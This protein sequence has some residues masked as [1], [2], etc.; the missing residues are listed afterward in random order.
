V[1][2][3]VTG[4]KPPTPRQDPEGDVTGFAIDKVYCSTPQQCV[5]TI[6]APGNL[7][8]EATLTEQQ[9]KVKMGEI[10]ARSRRAAED[11]LAEAYWKTGKFMSFDDARSQ[12]RR[13]L[14]SAEGFMDD[15]GYTERDRIYGYTGL[16]V[17]LVSGDIT[18][19]EWKAALE[20]MCSLRANAAQ[21]RIGT[22]DKAGVNY[23]VGSMPV[24]VRLAGWD[25]PSVT[26]MPGAKITKTV[27][28]GFLNWLY[29]NYDFDKHRPNPFGRAGQLSRGTRDTV[30]EGLEQ[31]FFNVSRAF[32]NWRLEN[33]KPEYE[34]NSGLSSSAG[35]EGGVIIGGKLGVT[36]PSKSGSAD[37]PNQFSL[38][39]FN[40][41]RAGF[42]TGLYGG[43]GVTTYY[44]NFDPSIGNRG[45]AFTVGFNLGDIGPIKLSLAIPSI[46]FTFTTRGELALEVSYGPGFGASVFTYVKPG[47]KCK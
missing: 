32:S 9:V 20:Q 5:D 36:G 22:C 37:D 42:V 31:A 2:N 33:C 25:V 12:A 21:G 4:V 46:A 43:G 47:V 34:F 44:A 18:L 19:D 10:E 45:T 41:P 39:R 27:G 11:Q 30:V 3:P 35:L 15:A 28:Q 7:D 23:K 24:G 26:W 6:T 29:G 8:S 1:G 40:S 16:A 17:G 13:D 38:F 14:D